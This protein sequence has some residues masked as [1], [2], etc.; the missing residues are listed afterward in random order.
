MHTRDQLLVWHLVTISPW[1]TRVTVLPSHETQY[2][3]NHQSISLSSPQYQKTYLGMLLCGG[4][5]TYLSGTGMA[6]P[7]SARMETQALPCSQS[8]TRT[9]THR[10]HTYEHEL[11]SKSEFNHVKEHAA[12]L[13]AITTNTTRSRLTWECNWNLI[14]MLGRSTTQ[15]TVC[16]CVCAQC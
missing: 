4:E 10:I 5:I 14:G 15:H 16:T 9:Q 1:I 12:T 3:H 8:R 2:T 7:R 13:A 6:S 11:E